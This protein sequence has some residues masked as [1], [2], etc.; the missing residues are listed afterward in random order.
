LP[1][2]AKSGLLHRVERNF[3]KQPEVKKVYPLATIARSYWKSMRPY[4]ANVFGAFAAYG[5]A[6]S[7]ASVVQPLFFRN[8]VDTIS[9]AVPGDEI[10]VAKI[11]KWFWYLAGIMAAYQTCFRFGD[12][13][14]SATKIRI[15]KN[16]ADRTFADLHRHSYRFFSETFSGSLVAKSKRYVMGFESLYDSVMFSFWM[17]AVQVAGIIV[18]LMILVPWVAAVFAVWIAGYVWLSWKVMRMKTVYDD[19]AAQEDS[20]LTA[21]L[22]DAMSN[23]LTVKTFAREGFEQ[24]AFAEVTSR[25]DDA[26]RKS[27]RFQ[28]NFFAVQVILLGLLE[29][30]AIGFSISLWNKGLMTLGTVVLVQWYAATVFM[31]IFQLTHVFANFVRGLADSSEMIDIFE[32]PTDIADPIQPKSLPKLLQGTFVF[33]DVDF[34]YAGGASVFEKFSVAFRSKEK[35]GIVG[36]SGAGKS[37][38]TKLLLRF[39]DPVSGSI[40]LDGIDIRDFRQED[41]RKT[42]AYVSQDASLFHRSLKENIAYGNPDATNEAIIAAAKKARA[43]EFIERLEKGYAT[44]VGERG[45]KLSGGERQRVALARAI[46]KDAPILVLDEA[47]SSLDTV[48]EKLI[49]DALDELMRDKTVIVIAHRLSTVRKMDRIL[50]LEGG[51]IV[52]DGSHEKLLIQHGVYANLW[53]HQTD[54]FIE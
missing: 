18:S 31:V 47:T 13:L 40:A 21:R 7:L 12:V 2:A 25:W 49:Q 33:Q 50:V 4:R 53:K 11:W 32:T 51:K 17:V 6:V 14:Y 38:I 20:N 48:S 52:E 19:E 43:H 34:R 28:N 10:S 29:L 5:L 36:S 54:G 46:L 37:T 16:I 45:V 3:M 15:I 23:V 9:A 35:V 42:I 39:L 44:L 30:V 24:E 26:R 8:I 22:S 1:K 41:L 27:A